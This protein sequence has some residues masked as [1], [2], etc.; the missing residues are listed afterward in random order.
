VKAATSAK[1]IAQNAGI[2]GHGRSNGG[3]PESCFI[4]A[5]TI[6][7]KAEGVLSKPVVNGARKA[8][9]V[10]KKTQWRKYGWRRK[11]G[12][13]YQRR[14]PSAKAKKKAISRNSWRRRIREKPVAEKR[15]AGGGGASDLGGRSWRIVGR[16]G[17]VV[18]YACQPVKQRRI[19]YAIGGARHGGGLCHP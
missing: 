19:W 15:Q 10:A 7:R 1:N 18:K 5:A 3:Q 6:M 13:L 11:L 17:D 16:R 12:S 4:F 14:Q 8:T 2:A 9:S